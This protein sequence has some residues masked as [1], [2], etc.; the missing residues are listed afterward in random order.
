L[1]LTSVYVFRIFKKVVMRYP[2]VF[3]HIG[4]IVPDLEKA[5]DFYKEVMEWYI[6]GHNLLL[7]I[8]I[9]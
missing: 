6:I 1:E 8:L 7:V 5:V 3:S 2:R 4:I 9:M